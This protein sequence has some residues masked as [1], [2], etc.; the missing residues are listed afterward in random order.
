MGHSTQIWQSALVCCGI[1]AI[2][3]S[4]IAPLRAQSTSG[5]DLNGTQELNDIWSSKESGQSASSLYSL[6]NRIQLM[7]GKSSGDFA[8][9]QQEGF[10]SAVSDFH[11]KQQEKLGKP[12]PVLQNTAPASAGAS[13]P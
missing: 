5:S 7:N 13:K 11:K 6:I 4:N 12:A 1:A 10:Q 8:A 3:G 9:E 2:L